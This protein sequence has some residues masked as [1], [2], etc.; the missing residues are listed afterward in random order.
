VRD[1]A[2]QDA[3][4]V[5]RLRLALLAEEGRSPLYANASPRA[6]DASL[7]LTRRQIGDSRS[8]IFVAESGDSDAR[9]IGTLRCTVAQRSPMLEGGAIASLT[10]AYVVP[11]CRRSGVL[12][13]LVDHALAWCSSRGVSDV[14]LRCTIEN[15]G[16][17]E[18][19]EALGFRVAAVVR[20]R[21]LES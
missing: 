21:I 12:R 17:N 11:E 3:E 15:A 4:A 13:A 6:G 5:A 19:W 7:R 20:R 18:T 16:A 10:M 14:R 9:V 8:P 2:P 1:A